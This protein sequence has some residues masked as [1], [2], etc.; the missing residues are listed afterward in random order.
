MELRYGDRPRPCC[1]LLR[2]SNSS[3][4]ARQVHKIR[5]T[6]YRRKYGHVS[7]KSYKHRSRTDIVITNDTLSRAKTPGPGS[8][9]CRCSSSLHP[10]EIKLSFVGSQRPRKTHRMPV[11]V[12]RESGFPEVFRG[13]SRHISAVEIA[14]G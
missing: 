9:A 11:V 14:R 7:Q 5:R 1:R 3:C 13:T 12:S 4:D 8:E 6:K 10:V 2:R